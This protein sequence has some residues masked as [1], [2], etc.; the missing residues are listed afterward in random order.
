MRRKIGTVFIFS[1]GV[2]CDVIISSKLNLDSKKFDLYTMR[3]YKYMYVNYSK[4]LTI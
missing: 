3:C 2:K 1:Q 4:S